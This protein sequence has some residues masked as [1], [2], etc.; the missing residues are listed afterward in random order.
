M[1]EEGS[2][3]KSITY[4]G[5]PSLGINDPKV[6]STIDRFLK[7]AAILFEINGAIYLIITT[8]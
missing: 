4:D 6:P 7:L 5:L 8:V 1:N 3:L 2:I